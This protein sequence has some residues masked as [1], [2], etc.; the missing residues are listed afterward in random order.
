MAGFEKCS[1]Y[2][3]KPAKAVGIEPDQLPPAFAEACRA[4]MMGPGRLWASPRF[5]PHQWRQQSRKLW[6]SH[7]F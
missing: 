5:D 6:L 1:G 7:Y 2:L 4:S 3:L